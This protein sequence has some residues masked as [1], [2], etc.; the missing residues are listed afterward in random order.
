MF[1]IQTSHISSISSR[2]LFTFTATNGS[3]EVCVDITYE[4]SKLGD[5]RT[6]LVITSS[7]GG[8][9]LCP[10]YGHCIA[11]RPQGPIIVRAGTLTSVPFKNVFT[12]HAS[13]NFVV[14]SRWRVCVDEVPILI[15]FLVIPCMRVCFF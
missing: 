3:I 8:D 7:S 9:Y 15:F 5:T 10:L 11:P 1:S 6:T 4:P 13:F 12:S 14:V 2:R